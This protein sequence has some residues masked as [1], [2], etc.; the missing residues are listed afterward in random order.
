[1]GGVERCTGAKAL[2]HSTVMGWVGAGR[3]SPLWV[4]LGLTVLD[5][6][7]SYLCFFDFQT[8]TRVLSYRTSTLESEAEALCQVYTFLFSFTN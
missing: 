3:S 6:D 4:T 7:P 1:M 2:Q 5:P 8:G